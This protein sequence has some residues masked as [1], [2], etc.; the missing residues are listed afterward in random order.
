[1]GFWIFMLMIC[2]LTPVV[3]IVFGLVFIKRPPN[4]V[5]TIY[6]YRTAMSMKN[7]DTWRFAHRFIGR[8]WLIIGAAA[9]P[10]SAIAM[11][12]VLDGDVA[13]IGLFGAVVAIAQCL[14]LIIS[15]I[16]TENALHKHFDSSGRRKTG[17]NTMQLK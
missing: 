4:K 15:I 14:L 16:P 3:M 7:D 10:V 8:L 13:G 6:G 9:L 12:L 1:M 5:N 17:S 2:L 11:L